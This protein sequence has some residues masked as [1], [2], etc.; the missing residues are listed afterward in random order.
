MSVA[1]IYF[2]IVNYKNHIQEIKNFENRVK[3]QKIKGKELDLFHS[4]S[5]EKKKKY[6]KENPNSLIYSFCEK[7]IK[8]IEKI[9]LLDI[10]IKIENELLGKFDDKFY[11]E[12]NLINFNEKL[13]LF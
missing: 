1:G 12:I 8:R 9:V 4:L 2:M 5:F 3:E 6:L 11:S 10:L 7:Y 13:K